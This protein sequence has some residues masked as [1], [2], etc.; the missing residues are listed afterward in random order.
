MED[1]EVLGDKELPFTPDV[2]LEVE[3]GNCFIKGESYLE[4]AIDFYNKITNWLKE[5][6]ATFNKPIH[7]MIRLNYFNTSSSRGILT[8]LTEMALCQQQGKQVKISWY[9]PVPDEDDIRVELEDFIIASD[10]KMDMIP[11]LRT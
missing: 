2:K 9:Y 8:L 10:V 6:L 4:D 7:L 11:E 5:H 1:F 3:T